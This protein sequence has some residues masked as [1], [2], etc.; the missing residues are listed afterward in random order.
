MSRTV[1]TLVALIMAAVVGAGLLYAGLSYLGRLGD[2]PPPIRLQMKQEVMEVSSLEGSSP[3]SAT[4][5]Q[6]PDTTVVETVCSVIP[7]DLIRDLTPQALPDSMAG[8]E[9][10]HGADG[11][12]PTVPLVEDS[13]PRLRPT[14]PVRAW[15]LP[16]TDEGYPA[17]SV[18]AD[19]T[20]AQVFD[21]GTGAG[22]T[23]RWDHPEPSVI[24]SPLLGI[25]ADP[26]RQ[27]LK[28]GVSAD[29]DVGRGRVRLRGGGQVTSRNLT[30]MPF[31]GAN[32]HPFRVS[33]P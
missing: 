3:T 15:W 2:G 12:G 11:V 5:Y 27:E 6:A 30:P 4:T 13:G 21:P 17:I 23:F 9:P 14:G 29:L 32:W 26:T 28:L 31:V 10:I 8:V 24:F 20:T 19:R 33:L 22:Q 16:I 25:E 7:E 1:L 18:T